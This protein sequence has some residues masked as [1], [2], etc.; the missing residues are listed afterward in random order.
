MWTRGAA[1]C[2]LS[3][4]VCS[5]TNEDMGLPALDRL[6]KPPALTTEPPAMRPDTQGTPPPDR[7]V[8]PDAGTV[9]DAGAPPAVDAGAPPSADAGVDAAK[10]TGPVDQGLEALSWE[11]IPV[12]GTSVFGE[13]ASYDR[14]ESSTFPFVQPG[15]KDFNNWLAICGGRPTINYGVTLGTSSCDPGQQGYLI[16]STDDGP[17]FVSR[18]F[19]TH[20][21]FDSKAPQDQ[22]KIRIYVDDLTTP[23]YEGKLADWKNGTDPTF[24]PPLVGWTSGALLS[25]QPI[26]Y[27]SKLRILLDDLSPTAIYYYQIGYHSSDETLPFRPGRVDGEAVLNRVR[28][29]ATGGTGRDVWADSALALAPNAVARPLEH[30]G[31]GTLESLRLIVPSASVELLAGVILRAVWDDA[32]SPAIELPL[33][34][35]FGQRQGLADFETLP[36]TVKTAGTSVTMTL[37]LPMP[38]ASHAHL[39][40]ENIGTQTVILAIRAEGSKGR[41]ANAGELHADFQSRH[42]PMQ[43]GTR[44]PIATLAGKGRYVGTLVSLEG[45]A[46]SALPVTSPFNFLEGD[47]VLVVDGKQAGHGTGTEDF[48]DGG[49]Y[50]EKGPFSSP[51]AAMIAITDAS[52]PVGQVTALRWQVMSD[53]VDFQ[54]SLDLSLEY[55][56]N[57]L[58]TAIDYSAVAFYY[59]GM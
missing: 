39:E 35:L 51:F 20:S 34:T 45:Q 33:G 41:A 18:I 58:N 4:V 21:E 49:W 15:N 27:T 30:D 43:T 7:V 59:L 26:S 42:A 3:V 57:R 23:V 54:R 46:D 24:A 6:E 37:A 29:E 32:A 19:Y 47:D 2:S 38:F 40:L 44:F 16:A 25:Y 8:N 22:E 9:V 17:G 10:R 50:F 11:S 31:P 53:A 28:K 48:L 36:M 55:G 56:T 13:F 14:D 12:L 5:C 1:V 52:S